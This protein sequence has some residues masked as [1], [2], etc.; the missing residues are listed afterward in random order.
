[1]MWSL[2]QCRGLR[3]GREKIETGVNLE[4]IGIN[5]LSGCFASYIGGQLRLSGC[6]WTNDE[7]DVRH[8][9]KIGRRPLKRDVSR[10][11]TACAR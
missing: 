10:L 5:N 4:R 7:K 3:L 6:S 9:S 8:K 11:K 1:M 2:A